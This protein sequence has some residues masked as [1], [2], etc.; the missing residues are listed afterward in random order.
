MAQQQRW[1]E[2]WDKLQQVEQEIEAKEKEL[3]KANKKILQA[4][5]KSLIATIEQGRDWL[6]AHQKDLMQMLREV[7][8]GMASS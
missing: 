6:V 7:E 5:R 1:A 4:N 8:T 3:Q 2:L